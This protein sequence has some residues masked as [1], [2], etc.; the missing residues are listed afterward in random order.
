MKRTPPASPIERPADAEWFREYAEKRGATPM[1]QAPTT[2]SDMQTLVKIVVRDTFNDYVLYESLPAELNVMGTLVRGACTSKDAL[3][4]LVGGNPI[5]I[6]M[7]PQE[8]T[9]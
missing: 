9:T 4:A 1:T 7:I 3:A 6:K 2:E 5:E 8:E